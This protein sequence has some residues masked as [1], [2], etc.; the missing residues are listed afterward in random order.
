MVEVRLS[1]MPVISPVSPAPPKSSEEADTKSN[2]KAEAGAAPK[3]PG[4][5]IPARVRD[6]G[7]AVH[8]PGIIG[9][10][11]DHLWIGR[12]NDDSV[13]LRRYLLLVGIVQMAGVMG[14]LTQ[15]LHRIR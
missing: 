6:D 3:N 12:F 9:R 5:G 14:L 1:A 13:A 10:H 2:T 15:G 11:V 8:Q 4:H 7:L